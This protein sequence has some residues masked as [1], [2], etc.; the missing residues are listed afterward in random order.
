M[1]SITKKLARKRKA[2]TNG[3]GSN[4]VQA[5]EEPSTSGTI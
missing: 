4:N 2:P 1:P 5:K 3:D